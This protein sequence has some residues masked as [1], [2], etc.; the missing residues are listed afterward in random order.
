[1]THPTQP[2]KAASN[3]HGGAPLDQQHQ[4]LITSGVDANLVQRA[5]AAGI[6]GAWLKDLLAKLAK[7]LL[8]QLLSG[9]IPGLGGG[10]VPAQAP[11]GQQKKSP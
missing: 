11:Q 9:G 3:P 1:M 4:E 2:G 8:E 5:A 6:G 10:G 7:T